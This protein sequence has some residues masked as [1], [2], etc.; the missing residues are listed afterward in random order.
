[1]LRSS[2][3]GSPALETFTDLVKNHTDEPT[4]PRTFA[5]SWRN[6]QPPSKRGDS[7]NS[8]G[9]VTMVGRE[10]REGIVFFIVRGF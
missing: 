5:A 9:N 2:K 4:R 6:D 1:M 8:R 10:I 3:V 7:G